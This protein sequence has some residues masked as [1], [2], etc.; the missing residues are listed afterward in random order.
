MLIGITGGIGSGKSTVLRVIAEQG[1]PVYDCDAQAKRII[2]EDPSVRRQLTA[3][4]GAEAYKGG[5]Y[6]T[7]Y[8]ASQVFADPDRLT[9]L[10]AIVHPAVARD[11]CAWAEGQRLAFVESAILFSS[12]ISRLCDAVVCIAAPEAV[13]VERVIRRAAECGQTITPE[14]VL[15]RI[16]TQQH[17]EQH[18]DLTIV[19]DGK[20]P[21][22]DLAKQII[23]FTQTV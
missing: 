7:Q 17:D 5:T 4:F 6:Q 1:Y 9:R 10:N 18:A 16:R 12:G 20:T 15:A 23:Q 22:T 13:R 8:V 14:Q 11:I 3:L 2:A 21:V 19:N